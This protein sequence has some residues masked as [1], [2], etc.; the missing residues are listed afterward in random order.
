M[1]RMIMAMV[2]IAASFSIKAQVSPSLEAKGDALLNEIQSQLGS[3]FGTNPDWSTILDLA[4][5]VIRDPNFQ[6][7]WSSYIANEAMERQTDPVG[8][9][10]G[11]VGGF[12]GCV[13]YYNQWCWSGGIGQLCNGPMPPTPPGVTVNYCQ[14]QF[15][16]AIN[17]CY[18]LPPL[19]PKPISPPNK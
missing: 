2:L 13:S 17:A 4:D 9:V 10:G 8:C 19:S 12:G 1:K 3:N 14:Y 18:G 6:T 16:N 7:Q 15:I 11:A 5:A